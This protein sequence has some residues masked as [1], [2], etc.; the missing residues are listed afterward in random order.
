MVSKY[1]ILKKELEILR[2]CGYNYGEFGLS[3]PRNF[4]EDY[5]KNYKEYSKIMPVSVAHM[6]N[7]S[8]KKRYEIKV[9]KKFISDH[10]KINCKNYVF[11]FYTLESPAKLG[12]T[13]LK[14][15][16]LKEL[17]DFCEKKKV[18]LNV[19]NTFDV[20]VKD[21]QPVFNKI[22]NIYFCLDTGH[23]NITGGNKLILDFI[24]NFG[25]KLNHI[26]AHDNFGGPAM[27]DNDRHLPVGL[28]KIDFPA[29]FK[30][31]KEVEFSS[32]ITSEVHDPGKKARQISIK[33]I[34]KLLR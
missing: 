14:I 15:A 4:Y 17:A 7:F 25:D 9:H 13:P 6:P 30:K 23:A 27:L 24:D 31:L 28:G 8:F 20:F 29:V 34:K 18:I 26:H 5:K 16:R 12:P 11:H 1:G 2:S 19:E 10:L 3:A 32:T 21:L 33:N 22:K